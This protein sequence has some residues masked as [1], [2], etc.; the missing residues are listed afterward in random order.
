MEE[1][2]KRIEELTKIL[3]DANYEYYVLANPSITD[4]EF[5][6]Y[7][8]ELETLELEYPQYAYENSPTKRVGGEVID[9]FEKVRHSIPMLSL[10][11][12]FSE[13]EIVNFFKRIE[14][15]EN[16]PEY[17]CEQKIDGLS[18]SLHYEHGHLI[19]A[20]TRGDGLVGENITHNVKTIKSVP[21]DLHR[22]IN[23]E[24]RGEIYMDYK[25]LEELN[26]KRK[27]KNE[28]LLQN[29]RNAAAGSIRQLDSKIAAERKLNSWIYHL[30]NPEDYGIK[31]HMEALNFMKEL[32]F[33]VNPNNKIIKTLDEMLGYIKEQADLRPNL[34]Y[35]IDG[36]VIKVNNLDM[37]KHL[38]YT[39]KYPRWA[40]AYKFPAEEVYTKLTD[41][42][43][44]VGR[45]GRITPNAVLEPTLVMG[46]TIKRATLHNEDYVLMK[47]L[48]IGDIVSIRKAGDVIPEVVAP[49]KERRNGTEK[50]FIM[51]SECPICKTK[52]EKK[53]GQVDYYCPNIH[54]PARKIE[55]LIH[56]SSK[57]AMDIDGLG[58]EIVEDFFNMG[59]IKKIEDIYSLDE[60]RK[61]LEE[62][63]GY[64][65][66]SIDNLLNSIK[67]SKTRSVERLLF[68]LG[69]SGIG[70]KTAL[71]LSKK[72][73]SID[74]LMIA[75]YDD[76]VSIKDI[77]PILA[78]NI[79]D[80]FE[81]NDNLTLIN[82]LKEIGI[83]TDYLG[84]TEKFNDL[85][86]NKKFVV[87]GTIEGYSRD[88]IE[89]IIE[90]YGG[91]CSGS[92]SKK[93]N[94]VIVGDSPG[95]KYQKALD[96]GIEI[97]NE[98]KV[99]DVLKTL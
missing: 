13:E 5:D 89:K 8:R 38:G 74:N 9:K 46:S 83:N 24:V 66:K 11:D 22:D 68:G 43:F 67:I 77:G 53:E 4:Q 76:L 57:N 99:L 42:I 18:V 62:L 39:S 40:I 16:K 36:I 91:S 48:K 87:T 58:E 29:V 3:N 88:E 30:P 75:T 82:N 14:K 79:V 80:Y 86:T 21:L 85:I 41:I 20:A 63:E 50:D 2:R 44:T 84:E 17:V 27:E 37:Q 93:T 1:A 19:S 69:I 56:Y 64:G 51:I 32:G 26:E 97:W 28:P 35:A 60:H 34:D 61:D 94:V 6:K 54:C 23:I 72:Y 59:F 96:L 47:D 90:N 15:E 31:T 65:K 71:L 25:T 95:S 10:P 70:D 81:N 92:V 98:E 49:L 7:L 55:S 73:K 45:T 12:V 33:K 78:R 52:L